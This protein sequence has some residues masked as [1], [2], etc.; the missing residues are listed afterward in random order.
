M[1]AV[2]PTVTPAV[3]AVA[4]A[5]SEAVAPIGALFEGTSGSSAA[6]FDAGTH[7]R[8]GLLYH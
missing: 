4:L 3:T 7:S 8:L 6:A 1:L 5:V 2:T